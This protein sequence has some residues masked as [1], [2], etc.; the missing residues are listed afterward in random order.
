MLCGTRKAC[1]SCS[2]L[3]VLLRSSRPFWMA[4]MW[5]MSYRVMA[6]STVSPY[7]R[8]KFMYSCEITIVMCW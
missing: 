1:S 3:L 5:S 8:W 6:S 7:T 4:R 2:A